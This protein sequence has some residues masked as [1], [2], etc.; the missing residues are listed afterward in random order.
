MDFLDQV[1]DPRKGVVCSFDAGVRCFQ[2]VQRR[3][4]PS[5]SLEL[6]YWALL[7]RIWRFDGSSGDGHIAFGLVVESTIGQDIDRYD[8]FIASHRCEGRSDA[9]RKKMRK[10]DWGRGLYK[11]EG[12]VK[13]MECRWYQYDRAR[14][15]ITATGD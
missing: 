5:A 1:A 2:L 11:E 8:R 15:Y 10:E 12:M 4:C 9:D 3:G 13:M 7:R 6:D 14:E